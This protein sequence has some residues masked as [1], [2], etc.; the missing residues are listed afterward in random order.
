M[1]VISILSRPMVVRKEIRADI[2]EAIDPSKHKIASFE[3]HFLT[4]QQQTA[5]VNRRLVRV[6]CE[7]V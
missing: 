4:V 5:N 6:E 7:L 2:V 1:A 3:L